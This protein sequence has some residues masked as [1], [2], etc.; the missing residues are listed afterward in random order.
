MVT[1]RS[2]ERG[3]RRPG[4][5]IWFVGIIIIR[6]RADAK[7]SVKNSGSGKEQ[8]RGDFTFRNVTARFRS[9]CGEGIRVKRGSENIRDEYREKEW[10]KK[11]ESEGGEV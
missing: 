6:P 11:S 4:T 9:C 3:T 2:V 10:A 8:G 7:P 5:R 1:I